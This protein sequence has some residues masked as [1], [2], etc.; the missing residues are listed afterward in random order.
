MAG[1]VKKGTWLW[2]SGD[3]LTFKNWNDGEPSNSGGVENCAVLITGD[4]AKGKWNDVDCGAAR[5]FLCQD[6]MARTPPDPGDACD[7]CPTVYNPDQKDAGA[8]GGNVC[9]K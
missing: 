2:V 9:E 6:K 8:D 1:R 4:T 3:P 7:T 5:A